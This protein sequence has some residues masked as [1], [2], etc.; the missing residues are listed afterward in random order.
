MIIY[1]KCFYCIICR[2]IIFADGRISEN[3]QTAQLSYF[4]AKIIVSNTTLLIAPTDLRLS[5]WPAKNVDYAQRVSDRMIMSGG[6]VT[7]VGT[8]ISKGRGLHGMRTF[9]SKEDL[10]W[11]LI[12]AQTISGRKDC[13]R[14]RKTLAYTRG[15]EFALV[16]LYSQSQGA[17]SAR[18][19]DYE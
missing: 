11:G 15:K 8:C 17:V 7:G 12:G 19:W 18:T 5:H 2:R 9:L 10:W 6:I 16:E 14:P 1:Y 3:F 13:F 4:I